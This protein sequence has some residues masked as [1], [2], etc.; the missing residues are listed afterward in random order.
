MKPFLF[1]TSTA[2]LEA[3]LY[4]LKMD[5][6]SLLA[7]IEIVNLALVQIK[8]VSIYLESYLYK[9]KSIKLAAVLSI[10]SF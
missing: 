1:K 8:N 7:I 10:Q 2:V 4:K 3:Q 9:S 5:D 6:Y